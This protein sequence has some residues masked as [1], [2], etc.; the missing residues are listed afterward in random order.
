MLC[1]ARA[2]LAKRSGCRS[3]SS[4]LC[5]RAE[6]ERPRIFGTIQRKLRQTEKTALRDHSILRSSALRLCATPASLREALRAGAWREIYFI[7][8]LP[9]DARDIATAFIMPQV[10]PSLA[11]SADRISNPVLVNI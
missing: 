10:R 6:T 11:F 5:F 3:I 2:L 4:E 1:F 9:G 7:H 8:A